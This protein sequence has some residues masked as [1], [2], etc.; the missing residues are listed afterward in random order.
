MKTI[1]F[2]TVIFLLILC[3]AVPT[4]GIKAQE[5]AVALA[6]SYEGDAFSGGEIRLKITVSKPAVALAGLEFILKYDS[7]YVTPSVTENTEDGREMDS[8]ITKIPQGWEQMCF[9]SESGYYHFRF[10]YPD[11]DG[12]YLDAAGALTLEI[13]FFVKKAGS[14]SFTADNADVI[15]IAADNSYTPMSGTGCSITVSADS[16]AQKLA[17]ELNGGEVANENGSYNLKIN[18]T[19][20]GDTSGIIAL[21]FALK[22]DKTVFAPQITENNNVQ[23]DCFMQN[24]PKNGWEQMCSFYE[25]ESMYILRFAAVTAESVSDSERLEVGSTLTISVPFRVIASE[26]NI[27]SFSVGGE[28]LLALNNINTPVSGNGSSL[29][30]S[31]EKGESG[32]IPENLG[33][34][35][36]DGCLCYVSEKTKVSDFL[37]PLN[38]FTLTDKNG[39]EKSTGLVCSGDILTDGTNSLQIAVIGDIDG[40]GAIDTFDYILARRIYFKTFSPNALQIMCGDANKDGKV[41]QYDYI[42]ITRHYFKTYVIGR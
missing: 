3:L 14:F 1:G 12:N 19:N 2:K 16:E 33:Y 31:V 41:D 20:L 29:F 30:V 17:V 25:S 6:F 39:N 32:V 21:Q 22:Y 37:L 34:T 9:H 23:M 7:E 11:G 38:G 42:L 4:V 5:S 10:A 24:M 40:T 28:S 36:K 35:V 27:G 13:P 18:I 8:L 26:G 15:A